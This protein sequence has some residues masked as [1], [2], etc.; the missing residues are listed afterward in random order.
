[1]LYYYFDISNMIL[2]SSKNNFRKSGGSKSQEKDHVPL[3]TA[4]LKEGQQY[5]ARN[6]TTN[7]D[8]AIIS[9]LCRETSLQ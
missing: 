7:K 1:M 2:G 4:E 5:L 6:E 3:N 8:I 9:A